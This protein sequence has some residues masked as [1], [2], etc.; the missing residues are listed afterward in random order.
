METTQA[1]RRRTSR[2]VKWLNRALLAL[3]AASLVLFAGFVLFLLGT[4]LF[5]FNR[6]LPGVYLHDVNLS[7]M[8]PEEIVAALDPALTYPENG[9]VVLQDADHNWMAKPAEFGVSIN[10]HEI[11]SNAL[12]V[13]RQGTFLERLQQ[14][15]DAWYQGYAI[16][17]VILFDQVVGAFYLQA[18][19]AAVDQPT[20]EA[21]LHI[22]GTQV[23]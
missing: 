21:A 13:G 2:I 20:I 7:G 14:Q 4:R 15:V 11:A 18:I 5:L 3:F 16:T 19:A 10:L 22:E 8:S 6:A 9:A 1:Y 17:P 23:L 12:A